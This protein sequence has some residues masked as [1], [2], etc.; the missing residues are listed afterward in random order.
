VLAESPDHEAAYALW[1]ET[2]ARVWRYLISKG[3][4]YEK[5]ADYILSKAQVERKKRIN[6]ADAIEELVSTALT[7]DTGARQA[8]S[9]TLASNH[10]E[11]AVPFLVNALGDADEE[12][13]QL[14]AIMAV[15]AIGTVATPAL[16]PLLSSDNKV[17]RQNVALSLMHLGDNRSLPYL[18][19]LAESDKDAGVRAIAK[20]AVGKIGGAKV[21]GSL[22]LF[23]QQANGYLNGDPLLVRDD[24]ASEV[25]WTFADGKLVAHAV[26]T[27]LFGLEQGKNAAYGALGIDPK[28]R[29]GQIILARTYIAEKSILDAAPE[30]SG[31]DGFKASTSNLGITTLAAGTDVIREAVRRNIESGMVP[32]AVSGLGML[33]RLEDPDN[34]AGSPLLAALGSADSRLSYESA[35]ALASMGAPLEQG[36]RD[37]IVKVLAD[38]V[39]EQAIKNIQVISSNK[40]VSMAFGGKTGFWVNASSKAREGMMRVA[41]RGADVVVIDENLDL[42]PMRVV[43]WV[44]SKAPDAKIILMAASTEK[45]EEVYGEKAD[46]IIKGASTADEVIKAVEGALEGVDLGE[47]RR[48]ATKIA[49][50]SAQTLAGLD[51]ALYNLAPASASLAKTAGREGSVGLFSLR[52]L[53]RGGDM[54]ALASIA[55]VL[56]DNLSDEAIAI[57]ACD[58]LGRIMARN[59]QADQAVALALVDIAKDGE[60]SVK[61]RSAAVAALGRSPLEVD[62]RTML[63]EALRVTPGANGD[64]DEDEGDDSDD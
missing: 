47:G 18:Q 34:L 58:A 52:A 14:H 10:G 30:G 60:A 51:P 44:R 36:T 45:A 56:K 26:P 4:D 6:D 54:K 7:G 40:N 2:D 48:Y 61:V 64:S 33:A 19:L 55:K 42:S 37:M 27:Q 24:D 1:K 32:S 22:D 62:Q 31:L 38:A 9:L 41:D 8:A 20:K 11:F 23:I 21:S 13:G 35:L 43:E 46:V 12:D 57:A 17:L 16:I 63:L 15:E 39:Q 59:K 29:E 49:E 50:A 28:S 3:G 53:A 5:I 25:L